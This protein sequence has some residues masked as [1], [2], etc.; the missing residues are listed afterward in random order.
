MILSNKDILSAMEAQEIVI[1]PFDSSAI[2]PCSVDLHLG[3]SFLVFRHG[4]LFRPN[5]PESILK[6]TEMVQTEGEPFL[7]SPN[8]FVLA[9]TKEKISIS[10]NLAATLEGKSSIAR[11]GIVVHAAGLVNPGTGLKSPTTLTLEIS[12]QANSTVELEPGMPIIQI[13]FHRLTSEAT[14]GY[15]DRSSSKYIGLDAP[16]V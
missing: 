15:D 5:Q 14:I 16:K 6:N 9:S 13:I 12:Q 4:T 3:S 7:L 8:Q 1:S 2:G 10:R 11:L